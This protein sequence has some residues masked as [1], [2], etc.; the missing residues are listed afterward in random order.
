MF[1]N[2]LFELKIVQ[3]KADLNELAEILRRAKFHF[4]DTETTGLRVRYPGE[5]FPVGFTFAVEDEVDERV[6]YIPVMHEFEGEYKSHIDL[7]KLKL[8]PKDF[9]SFDESAWIGKEFYNMD[10][11]LVI[12]TL[13]PILEMWNVNNAGVTLITEDSYVD[14]QPI[15]PVRI[16]HNQSFDWHVIAN[17]GID[18]D[19]VANQLNFDDTMIMMHT[20]W[21]EEGKKLEKA[22]ERL[23][24]IK[25]TDYDDVVATVTS[26]EKKA[27]GFKTANSKATFQYSQIPIGAQ[28]SAEDVFFMKQF[29]PELIRE[30]KQDEQYELYVENRRPFT[31]VLW[32]MERRGVKLDLQKV[33]EMQLIAEKELD[34]L[35]GEMY[36]LAEIE[37]NIES[38][39]QVAEL[40]F[41]WRK[42]LKDKSG[43]YKESCNEK[44]LAKAFGF[45][46]VSWTDGGKDKDKNLRAPQTNADSLEE[47]LRKEYKDK[48]KIKGQEFV[49]KLLQYNKLKKLHHTYMIGLQEE[50]Y[51]DGKIHCSF[52]Q[53]GTDSWRLSSSNPNL[54][55]LPRPLEKPKE[56]KASSFEKGVDYA[57]AMRKYNKEKAEYDF[58]I[59]FEIR[60]LFLPENDDRIFLS[61]D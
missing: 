1:H 20:R 15:T 32:N 31:K 36:G 19:K 21:E 41:G 57:N 40:L 60:S 14:C 27:S 52:N 51:A 42:Q 61:F 22:V 38:G 33:K 23:F 28:Y 24:G 7:A 48:R 47:I 16:A 50:V 44:I 55:N 6:F 43:G 4:W 5:V 12:S 46:V 54:Q 29:Y 8:N 25:K 13:K 56:P 58:W 45:P 9:P 30:L 17:C 11:A 10:Y 26:E 37:I 3:T 59:Q 2:N 39:Q 53:E 35:R 49:R 18:I 34:A